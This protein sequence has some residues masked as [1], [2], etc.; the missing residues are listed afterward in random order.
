MAVRK[1][2]DGAVALVF[3]GCHKALEFILGEKG[4]GGGGAA[5]GGRLFFGCHEE[6]LELGKCLTKSYSVI[7]YF[8][9][10]SDCRSL[11]RHQGWLLHMGCR[12]FYQISHWWEHSF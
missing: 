12:N 2:N 9:L 5:F 7:C 6:S 4:Y 1:E 11:S 3:D 10:Y 8:K